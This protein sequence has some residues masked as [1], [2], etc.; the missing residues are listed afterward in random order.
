[1]SDQMVQLLQSRLAEAQ[2]KNSSY[3]LRAF[4]VLLGLAPAELSLILNGKRRITYPKATQI[5]DRLSIDPSQRTSLLASV[6]RRLERKKKFGSINYIQLS[7]DEFRVIADWHY[8]A[9]LS[10]AETASFQSDTS[11]IAQRLGIRKRDAK[12]AI[13]TLL[14]LG[15][16]QSEKTRNEV[17]WV[18]TG[19]K[20]TTTNDIPSSPIRKNHAQGLELAKSALQNVPFELREFGASVIAAD[21]NLLPKAKLRLRKLRREIA[22]LLEGGNKSEV[23]RLSVQLIPLSRSINPKRKIKS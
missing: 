19:K 8:L 3:S 2:S 22:H 4:S 14:R 21:P 12:S 18:P 15:L 10:L 7:T 5:L 13:D 16:I 11:W 20:F 17:R 6:P 1:M 9:I 23:Y